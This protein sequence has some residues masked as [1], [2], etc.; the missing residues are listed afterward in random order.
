VVTVNSEE[1]SMAFEF[2]SSGRPM[3]H[4]AYISRDTGKIYW[5]SELVDTEDEFP[6]DLEESNRYIAIPHKNDLDLGRNLAMRFA[7]SELPNAFEAVCAAFE[8]R[9]AY[10]RFKDILAA[11]GLLDR[12]YTFEAA[13]TREALQSWC[14][15]NQIQVVPASTESA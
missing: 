3:E 7:E 1:L 13:C 6:D 5:V 14:E 2:V 9:G 12:W 11:H 10:G 4:S 8:H 15:A